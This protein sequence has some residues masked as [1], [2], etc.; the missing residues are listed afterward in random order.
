MK[1]GGW[2]QMRYH[3]LDLPLDALD[4]QIRDKTLVDPT[5]YAD[6]FERQ[7]ILGCLEDRLQIEGC[8]EIRTVYQLVRDG[9]TWQ[10]VAEHVG[11]TDF[12]RVKRRFNRWI[13]KAA[14]QVGLVPSALKSLATTANVSRKS[15]AVNFLQAASRSA[16][17]SHLVHRGTS[18]RGE[19]K[20]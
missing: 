4:D 14:R 8:S 1:S 7:I 15:R 13:K 5:N 12:E 17:D 10:E 20:P 9:Y 6:V 2:R 11:A 16:S 18:R 19:S 3:N